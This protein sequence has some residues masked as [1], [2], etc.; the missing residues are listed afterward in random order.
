[1]AGL[2]DPAH[3]EGVAVLDAQHD[4]FVG[5]VSALPAV[6]RERGC[7]RGEK[8][9]QQE[10]AQ[11]PGQHRGGSVRKPRKSRKRAAAAQAGLRPSAGQREPSAALAVVTKRDANG[12][13]SNAMRLI[14]GTGRPPTRAGAKRA[15]RIAPNRASSASWSKPSTFSAASFS[16]APSAPIWITSSTL[17]GRV[18]ASAN[19]SRPTGGKVKRAGVST[20]QAS[21]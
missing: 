17:P 14:D 5:V 2:A 6:G 11:G 8:Q 9:E 19:S 10:E 4:R 7:M 12:S 20:C 3:E 15:W 13:T 18:R 21:A 16:S 1:G